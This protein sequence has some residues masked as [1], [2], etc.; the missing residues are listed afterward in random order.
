MVR[1]LV[2]TVNWQAPELW[3]AAPR[4]DYKVD[5]FSAAMVYWEMLNGWTA[6]KA[7]YPWEG[8]NEHYI[9]EAVGRQNKRPSVSGLRKHWGAEPV[10]LMERMWHQDPAERP[11]MSDVVADLEAILAD[12]PR[13][14]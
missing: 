9:Y 6:E 10:N 7:K 5:V 13:D 14:T 3:H 1:S 11:T 12:T 2:G 8:N 4:Y